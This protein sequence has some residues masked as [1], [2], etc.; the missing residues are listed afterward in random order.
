[1]IGKKIKEMRLRKGYS[2][3]QLAMRADVSKSYLSQIERGLQSNPSLQFLKKI[4]MPLGTNIDFFL[5]EEY[6]NKENYYELDDEW[7]S[8]IKEAVED[9]L[10][11]EDFKEYL[12][13]IKF[14]TWLK[15]QNK[16]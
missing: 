3:G 6:Y 15:E 7:K 8:L 4:S 5:G 1:M 2:L 12:N 14:Q 16:E 11:K 10:Q 13:Y 9:G